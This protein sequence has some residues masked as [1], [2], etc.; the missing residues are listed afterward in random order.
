MEDEIKWLKKEFKLGATAR[1]MG[2]PLESCPFVKVNG[3]K[4]KSWRAGWS[5]QDQTI[6]SEKGVQQWK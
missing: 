5:D 2:R 1:R 3:F 6:N 4:R